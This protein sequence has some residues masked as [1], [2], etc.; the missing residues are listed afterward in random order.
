ME[1]LRQ[2]VTFIVSVNTNSR[3]LEI[4]IYIF[5]SRNS[6]RQPIDLLIEN[7]YIP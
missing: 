2:S 4:N 3:V 1:K 6:L 7:G 5:N